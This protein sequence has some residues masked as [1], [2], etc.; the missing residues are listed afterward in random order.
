MLNLSGKS[1]CN[2]LAVPATV[3]SSAT[4]QSP[5][6]NDGQ[7]KSSSTILINNGIKK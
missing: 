6:L 2:S 5:L 4:Q 7:E 3:K 1:V